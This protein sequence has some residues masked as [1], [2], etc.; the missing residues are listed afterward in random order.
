MNALKTM[1][2]FQGIDKVKHDCMQNLFGDIMQQGGS[3]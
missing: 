3:I 1:H 2:G